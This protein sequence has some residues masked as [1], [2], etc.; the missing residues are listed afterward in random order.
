MSFNSVVYSKCTVHVIENWDGKPVEQFFLI[1]T[2][3]PQKPFSIFKN[4]ELENLLQ[5]LFRHFAHFY[6]LRIFKNLSR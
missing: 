1:L 5:V 2:F 3:I 6:K 4:W